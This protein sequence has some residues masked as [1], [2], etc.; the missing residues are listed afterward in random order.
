M[1]TQ[2]TGRK[3]KSVESL[4]KGECASEILNIMNKIEYLDK[5]LIIEGLFN[6]W[7]VGQSWDEQEKYLTYS[8][9][10]KLKLHKDEVQRIFDEFLDIFPEIQGNSKIILDWKDYQL[11][12]LISITAKYID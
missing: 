4:I 6:K 3:Y 5:W 8:M 11:P 10:K 1:K 2:L 9:V 7:F 12:T